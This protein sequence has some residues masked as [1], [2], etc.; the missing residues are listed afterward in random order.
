MTCVVVYKTILHI[1]LHMFDSLF[2]SRQI[3]KFKNQRNPTSTSKDMYKTN[4][5]MGNILLPSHIAFK[6][7]ATRI[8]R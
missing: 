4:L 1:N 3:Q 5:N 2:I 7:E 8:Y 6:F